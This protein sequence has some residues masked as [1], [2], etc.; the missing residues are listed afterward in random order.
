LGDKSLKVCKEIIIRTND[1]EYILDA[2]QV[3]KQL[4][5]L[6]AGNGVSVEESVVGICRQLHIHYET[7]VPNAAVVGATVT[8]VGECMHPVL[9]N[10][11]LVQSQ[12]LGNYFS[13]REAA[14]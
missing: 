8:E 1:I 3:G 4:V 14:Y 11:H 9:Q 7:A 6:R 10:I 12:L 5:T 2:A 13:S